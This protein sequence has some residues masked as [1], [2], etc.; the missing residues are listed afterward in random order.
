MCLKQTVANKM[1]TVDNIDPDTLINMA[2]DIFE[3]SMHWELLIPDKDTVVH[4]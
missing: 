4:D 2:G 3:P 1:A